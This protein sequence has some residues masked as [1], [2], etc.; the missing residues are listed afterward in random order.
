MMDWPNLLRRTAEFEK[1]ANFKSETYD[2]PNFKLLY[3]ENV[4]TVVSPTSRPPPPSPNEV[5]L[6]K[7]SDALQTALYRCLSGGWTRCSIVVYEGVYVDGL[8]D[9]PPKWIYPYVPH[10]FSVEIVGVKD[11]RLVLFSRE[12]FVVGLNLT[13]R[14]VLIYD[15]RLN[16]QERTILCHKANVDFHDVKIH[17][18]DRSAYITQEGANLS[19]NRCVIHAGWRGIWSTN[20]GVKLRQTT[21]SD[22]TGCAIMMRMTKFEA[23]ETKFLRC[24]ELA[25]IFANSEGFFEDCV[26]E[27]EVV[28]ESRRDSARGERDVSN[29]REASNLRGIELLDESRVVAKKCTIRGFQAGVLTSGSNSKPMFDECLVT[30]CYVAFVFDFNADGLIERCQIHGHYAMQV[31]ND[32]A[33]QIHFRQNRIKFGARATLLKDAKSITPKHDFKRLRTTVMHDKCFRLEPPSRGERSDYTKKANSSVGSSLLHPQFDPNFGIYHKQC[34][35]CKNHELPGVPK[36]KFC[37]RCELVCYC[38]KECQIA[39]WPDHKLI[40]KR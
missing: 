4:I 26:F 3:P 22:S 18:A 16:L 39:S 13:L 6:G 19:L 36:F 8:T 12:M 7:I 20:C 10:E 14:N 34:E 31:T 11:V 30:Q 25:A 24:K 33:G 1:E 5:R 2:I 27:S 28:D 21:F 35:K 32:I 23:A 17:A 38:S 29:L 40:C 9:V 37:K 15:C